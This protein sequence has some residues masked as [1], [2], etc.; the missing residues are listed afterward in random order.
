MG[1]GAGAVMVLSFVSRVN[2]LR[3]A[4]SAKAVEVRPALAGR[5]SRVFLDAGADESGERI[6]V[7]AASGGLCR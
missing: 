4:A 6:H 1:Q 2:R 5:L 3:R 7:V